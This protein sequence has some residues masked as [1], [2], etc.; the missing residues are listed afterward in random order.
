MTCPGPQPASS[1]RPG[2]Q[3]QRRPIAGL[4]LAI[5]IQTGGRV[6]VHDPIALAAYLG[7]KDSFDQSIADFSARY[8]DQNE[9]DYQSF[10][11]AVRQGR[12]AATTNV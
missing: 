5:D 7:K 6:G 11:E 10:A 12:L 4:E 2:P 9:K 1:S 8:A 3:R